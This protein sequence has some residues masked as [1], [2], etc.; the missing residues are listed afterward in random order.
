MTTDVK[1]PISGRSFDGRY[2]T[3]HDCGC[4]DFYHG[5]TARCEDHNRERA[6]QL[7]QEIA[8]ETELHIK[9]GC[10]NTIATCPRELCECAALSSPSPAHEE[11]S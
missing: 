3:Q 2:D 1:D 8:E 5:A 9:R 7:E 11:Q 4:V 6:K 10:N